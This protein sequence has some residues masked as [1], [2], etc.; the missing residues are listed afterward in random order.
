MSPV[1]SVKYLS[2]M[3]QTKGNPVKSLITGTGNMVEVG[4]Q[5]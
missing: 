5:K 2:G 4:T 1:Q 3:D